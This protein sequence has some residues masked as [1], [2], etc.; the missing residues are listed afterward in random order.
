MAWANCLAVWAGMDINNLAVCG[1]GN[2]HIANS[3]I[4]HLEKNKPDPT[5]TLVL[6]MW[7][8]TAR[9]DWITD[10]KMRKDNRDW[11]YQYHYDKHN[12]LTTSMQ[13]GDTRL[14]TAFEQYRVYQSKSS[15]TLNTWLAITSLSNYL[16]QHGYTYYYTSYQD[17][18]SSKRD[19]FSTMLDSIDLTLDMSHWLTTEHQEFL[20]EFAESRQ[21]VGADNWH[22][23]PVGHERWVNE[24]LE[25]KLT[26]KGILNG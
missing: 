9:V 10:K 17:I 1:A 12:D 2:Q 22:P 14:K 23:T 26:N 7:S 11:R 25:S 15:E 21:L 18:F 13:T 6:A 3:I 5:T 20:G 24:I 4:L 19:N 16:E 8:G